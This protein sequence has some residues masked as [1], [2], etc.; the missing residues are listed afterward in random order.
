M[1][2][3]KL[4]QAILI[5]IELLFFIVSLIVLFVLPINTSATS[6][7][8][9]KF[10]GIQK[11]PGCGLGHAIHH[12]LH[13]QFEQSFTHHPLGIVAVLIFIYRI[14]IL[15]HPKL[16]KHAIKYRKFCTWYFAR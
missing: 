2:I 1:L 11:C 16:K 3:K 12:A 8:F 13:M 10:I 14:F 5:N 4:Y 6:L 15:L 9:F 7:C